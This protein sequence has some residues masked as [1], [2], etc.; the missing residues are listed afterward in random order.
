MYLNTISW[1]AIFAGTFISLLVYSTLASLGLAIGGSSLGNIIEGGQNAGGL[2]IGTAIWLVFSALV[3]LFFGAFASSRSVADMLKVHGA[4]QGLVI[5]SIFYLFL[6]SQVGGLLGALGKGVGGTV[7]LVGSAVGNMSDNPEVRD[8][9]ENA[10][11]DQ[12][13]L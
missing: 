10:I 4:I 9:V 7:G 13:N 1:K 3:A 5:A 2:G 8:T 6:L 12:T 11:G